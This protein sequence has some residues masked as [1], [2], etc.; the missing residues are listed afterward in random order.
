M[1]R[2]QWIDTQTGE[3]LKETDDRTKAA[4]LAHRKALWKWEDKE[5]GAVPSRRRKGRHKEPWGG[6]TGWVLLLLLVLVLLSLAHR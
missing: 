1:S 5:R 4:R 3:V 6:G 2:Y